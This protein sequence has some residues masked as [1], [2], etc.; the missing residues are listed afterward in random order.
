MTK[1]KNERIFSVLEDVATGIERVAN[2]RISS[3]VV[4]KNDIVSIGINKLKTHPFQALHS[5]HEE[6]IYWHA[7]NH[8]IHNALKLISREQFSKSTL[9]VCRIDQAQN[10]CLAKPCEG[11]MKAI[12]KFKF[13]KLVYTTSNS[14]DTV[15]LHRN[16][17]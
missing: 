10:Y 5:R 11:C 3:A 2:A 8:A 13:K 6:S 7:E 14:F 9:Y 4:Y 16:T 1:K 12:N 17:F 15:S